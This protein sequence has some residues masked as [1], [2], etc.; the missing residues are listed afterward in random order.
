MSGVKANTVLNLTLHGGD[1]SVPHFGCFREQKPSIPFKR[2]LRFSERGDKRISV[3]SRIE[4]GP[5]KPQLEI[6]LILAPCI[7]FFVLYNEPKNALLVDKLSHSSYMFRHCY[8]IHGEF[9]VS[10][11]PG[12]TIMSNAVVGN[13]I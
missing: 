10:T 12:Y 9:V 8:F 13:I 5:F 2:K 7:F 3:L 1:W 4:I 6:I 11:L